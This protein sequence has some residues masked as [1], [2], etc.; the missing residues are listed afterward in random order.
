MAENKKLHEV[1]LHC[2]NSGMTF[3]VNDSSSGP[4]VEIHASFFGQG[5]RTRFN[6]SPASLEALGHMFLKASKDVYVG[7][8]EWMKEKG[9]SN[10]EGKVYS[11]TGCFVSERDYRK[12]RFGEENVDGDGNVCKS[13][14]KCD[15]EDEE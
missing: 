15:G 4:E 7:H 9:Y 12:W 1:Y 2:S 14:C 5:T 11:D 6:T 13:A 8:Q 10:P 3:R